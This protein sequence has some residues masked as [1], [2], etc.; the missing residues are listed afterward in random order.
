M[1][2]GVGRECY[3]LLLDG[4]VNKYF[5]LMNFPGIKQAYAEF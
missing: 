5:L 3:V 1:K 4:C 2:L